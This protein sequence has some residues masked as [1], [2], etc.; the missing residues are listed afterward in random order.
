M[1]MV[2]YCFVVLALLQHLPLS[3]LGIVRVLRNYMT[4]SDESGDLH[5]NMYSMGHS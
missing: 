3:G 5:A 1:R 4:G 2:Y